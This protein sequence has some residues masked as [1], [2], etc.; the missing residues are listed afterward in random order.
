MNFTKHIII[1]FF[2]L[3]VFFNQAMSQTEGSLEKFLFDHYDQYLEKSISHQY[4]KLEDIQPIIDKL[5]E[6]KTFKVKVLGESVEGRK[7]NLLKLGKGKTNVLLWSQMHGNEPTATMAL[8]DMFNFF[9]ASDELDEFREKVLEECTLY[10]VPMLNPDGAEKYQRRNALDFDINR[11]AQRLQSPEAK[12]LKKIRDKTNADFGFNLHDQS[13][14]Y[15]AGK[16]ANQASISFLAPAY[17]YEK[18]VND[19]RGNA[20]KIIGILDETLQQ[21]IPGHIAKYDDTFEPRAFGDNIQKWGTSTILVES[22]GYPNDP[23]K[24]HL[25]KMNFI[26]LLKALE[27]ISTKSYEKETIERYE[28]IPFNKR[29]LFDLIVRNA[30]VEVQGKKYIMDIGVNY[31]QFHENGDKA[32]KYK[33]YIVELGDMSTFYGYEEIDAQEQEVFPGLISEDTFE[34]QEELNETKINELLSKG[35]TF[36]KV[37]N[38]EKSKG[39]P[40]VPINLVLSESTPKSAIELGSPANFTIGKGKKKK[41][42]VIN[43]FIY[44]IGEKDNNIPNTVIY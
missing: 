19:V 32:F 26:L 2:L 34:N 24:Q 9:L 1:S 7:I 15:S 29:Y 28:A 22:G 12:I 41:T 43:G 33:G 17:N 23:E 6:D 36:A 37:K 3:Q 31:H 10:F 13:T 20:M 40:Q 42:A 18:D 38:H 14:L 21:F 44:Q 35:I 8:M 4:L 11:D 27:A 5:D 30:K 39:L 25:R 16:S